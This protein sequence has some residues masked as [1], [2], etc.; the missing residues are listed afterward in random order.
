MSVVPDNLIGIAAHGRHGLG[1]R[2]AGC[3]L[4]GR[5]YPKRIRGTL[6]FLSAGGT[7]TVLP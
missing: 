2:R 1:L 4:L 5:E 7:G 6:A 3:Q